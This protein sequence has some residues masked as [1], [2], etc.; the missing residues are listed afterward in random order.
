MTRAVLR[1]SVIQS[2]VESGSTLLACA[3]VMFGVAL[4]TSAALR[5]LEDRI[6]LTHNTVDRQLAQQAAEVALHDAALALAMTPDQLSPAEVQGAHRIGEMTGETY[7]Y[8]GYLQPCELPEYVLE[9]ISAS[10][11]TNIY[12]VTAHGKGHNDSTTVTLQA[13]FAVQVC[14]NDSDGLQ[15]T[16]PESAQDTE[17]TTPEGTVNDAVQNPDQ[18]EVLSA[19]EQADIK[20]PACV[21]GV[22]RLTWRLLQA[23]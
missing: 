15:N 7:A 4:L 16:A 3:L 14:K 1:T 21:P 2:S 23:T 22:R 6:S 5:S 9:L 18:R 8:G 17:R 19:G 11:I 10:D 13:E 12:R 20:R